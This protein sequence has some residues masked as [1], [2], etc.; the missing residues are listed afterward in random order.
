MVSSVI[1]GKGKHSLPAMYPFSRNTGTGKLENAIIIL[2]MPG[3]DTYLDHIIARPHSYII[4]TGVHHII[5]LLYNIHTFLVAQHYSMLASRH[6]IIYMHQFSIKQEL[7]I[8]L[9][10]RYC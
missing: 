3:Q 5:L 10:Y 1:P 7:I 6:G 8:K 9:L 4:Y 2:Y